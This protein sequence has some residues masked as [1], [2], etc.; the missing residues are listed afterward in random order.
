MLPL[1]TYTE[2]EARSLGYVSITCPYEPQEKEIFDR[3]FKQMEGTDF[4]VVLDHLRRP[5]IF[6]KK[7]ELKY[8]GIKEV[9]VL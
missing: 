2:T 5:E 6:R 4:L 3:A 8:E 1:I 7:S 9:V